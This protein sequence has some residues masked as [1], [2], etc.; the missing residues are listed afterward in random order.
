M[1]AKYSDSTPAKVCGTRTGSRV[2][3]VKFV[4]IPNS[5][6]LLAVLPNIACHLQAKRLFAFYKV[7]NHFSKHFLKRESNKFCSVVINGGE[8]KL[9]LGLPIF[10]ELKLDSKCIKFA[11]CYRVS[12]LGPC[13]VI[14]I[15]IRE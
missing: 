11:A 3:N 9:E 14:R 8:L 5:A 7:L 10:C 13:S 2:L 12:D 15:Q 1:L 6:V 4:T